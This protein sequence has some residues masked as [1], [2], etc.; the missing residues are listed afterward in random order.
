MRIAGVYLRDFAPFVDQ[1]V[2]FA[3]KHSTELAEVHFFV[4]QNGTGK[5]RL[6]S[7]L[8]AACGNQEELEFRTNRFLSTVVASK[9]EGGVEK[10]RCFR[11]QNGAIAD[12]PGPIVK[13]L[14]A[15]AGEQPSKDIGKL[16]VRDEGTVG[17]A[18]RSV[19]SLKDEKV[20]PMGEVKWPK[21]SQFLKFTHHENE[22]AQLCQAI[23]N[24]KVTMGIV[25][26]D[27]SNRTVRMVNALDKAI[28]S[29]TGQN[30]VLTVGY[31]G[32]EFRLKVSW[33][34]KEMQ[35][36]QLPDGLRS[37]CG[38]LISCV[39]K[40]DMIYPDIEKPL[41]Q[42]LILLLDEPDA[43]LHPAWQRKLIPAVQ[44]L[45]PN[46]QIFV[47]TH[48]P[49]VISSVSKGSIYIFQADTNG[50]VSIKP[51]KPCGLGDSYI[52]VVEDVLGIKEQFDPDTELL[53]SDFRAKREAIKTAHSLDAENELRELAKRIA[54][55][56]DTL[57]FM[58]GRE[59][60]QLETQLDK[61]AG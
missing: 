19:P 51:A 18:F 25:S 26:S 12:A 46:A 39:A 29:F 23:S 16:S 56:G 17:M 42:P 20:T 2:V 13:L 31:V 32:A 44:R 59:M 1:S 49:F 38:W 33:A 52:D 21:P 40:M 61:L 22:S 58:M 3:P 47:A 50:N 8:A 34:G 30:L 60:A 48:S 14:N 28:Q 15:I 55:R 53:L 57:Q 35:L 9:I 45:L 36:K 5:T 37:V 41:E 7:L 6:L 24:L 10:F 54:S 4:G 27:P 43:H 11:P